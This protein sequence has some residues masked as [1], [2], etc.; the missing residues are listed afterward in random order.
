M[1]VVGSTWKILETDVCCFENFEILDGTKCRKKLSYD[2]IRKMR[3]I[4]RHFL[5]IRYIKKMNVEII[6][7]R[8]M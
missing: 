3:M 1:L 5:R 4:L 2:M 8:I 7:N 6:K